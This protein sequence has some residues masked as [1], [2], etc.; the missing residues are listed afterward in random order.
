MHDGNWRS[1]A[2]LFPTPYWFLSSSTRC[3]LVIV[4]TQ[5]DP[6]IGL[7]LYISAN[8]SSGTA[9]HYYV[10]RQFQCRFQQ[11]QLRRVSHTVASNCFDLSWADGA[12]CSLCPLTVATCCGMLDHRQKKSYLAGYSHQQITSPCN[13]SKAPPPQFIA[14]LTEPL[15]CCISM[16]NLSVGRF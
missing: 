13:Q 1:E 2:L 15:C 5:N 3:N 8:F 10:P 16:K 6:R 7:L 9:R 14:W 11:R 4:D 12:Y